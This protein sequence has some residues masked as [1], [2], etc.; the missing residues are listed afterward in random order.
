MARWCMWLRLKSNYLGAIA[1][2]LQEAGVGLEQV[3]II[4]PSLEDVFISCMKA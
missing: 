3:T 1:A 4:E 2:E